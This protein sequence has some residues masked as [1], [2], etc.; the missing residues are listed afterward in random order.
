M[1]QLTFRRE[2][3][4]VSAKSAVFLWYLDLRSTI[5]AWFFV[6]L[7]LVVWHGDVSAVFAEPVDAD[8]VLR[9]G[10]LHDGS[11]AEPAM[12][13]VAVRGDK[14]IAVGKF[15]AGRVGLELDCRGLVVAPGFIDL[16]NHSDAQVVERLTR[17]NVN[18]VRQGC[19]TIVT[20][21]CGSGPI[22]VAEYYRKI[23]AAGAGTNVAHL[24]PQGNLREAVMGSV[25]RAP[26]ADELSRMKDLAR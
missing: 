9:G 1:A 15:E 14:I 21:N 16:H 13:D 24:L 4:R 17:A 6:L 25:Q 22:E 12:G 3:P 23:D 10:R 2:S 26:T 19:T 18:F 5:V 11:G 20:G 7:S 8:L